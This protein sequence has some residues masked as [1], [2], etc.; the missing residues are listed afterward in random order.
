MNG[1]NQ[2]YVLFLVSK[3]FQIWLQIPGDIRGFQ[4]ALRYRLERRFDSPDIVYDRESQLCV[5]FIAE[6]CSSKL[7][8]EILHIIYSGESTVPVFLIRESPLSLSLQRR[9]SA[10]L[11]F[12]YS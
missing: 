11:S 10:N 8:S 7:F 9:V 5:L 4:F 12:I 3:S 2:L 1:L 6:S